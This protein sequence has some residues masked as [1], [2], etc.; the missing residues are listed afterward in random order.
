[1]TQQQL[2]KL[3]KGSYLKYSLDDNCIEETINARKLLCTARFDF[4]GILIYI[5][6]KVQGVKN[7]NWAKNIYR[8]RT[9]AMT[10]HKLC[11][12][13][14]DAKT[15]FDDFV[16][17]LDKLINDFQNDRFNQDQTLIP[18]DK[19]YVPMDG[20][21]RVACAAYFD[22]NVN[23]LRFPDREYKF[24]GYQYLQHELLPAT[25]AD[26]MALESTRWHNDLYV[27]FFW[28]QAHQNTYK[29]KKAQDII[30]TKTDVMYDVKY[31]LSYIAIRNLMIQIYGHMDWLGD[32]DNDFANVTVKVNEVWASNGKV[33]LIITRGRSCEYI[34][35]LKEE[36]REMFGIGLSS[37][38]STDNM[39][40]TK[41]AL[42]ALLNPLSRDFLQ[43]AKPTAFKKSFKLIEKFKETVK[44]NNLSF[45][46]FI[47][48]SSTVLA[49]YGAREAEDLDFYRLP[50]TNISAFSGIEDIEEHDETQKQFYEY[51]ITDYILSPEHFFVF[52]EVKFMSLQNLL[53]FK[54]A[55]YS[56]TKDPKDAGDIGL[57]KNYSQKTNALTQWIVSL[58][59]DYLRRQR[60]CYDY[61]YALIFWRRKEI[62]EKIGLYKPLKALKTEILKH[63]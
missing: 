20:A 61:I 30:Y 10:S 31:K 48:D 4:Y 9:S 29:L 2:N 36:I 47:I 63:I 7:L 37:C 25:I 17:V 62:L 51:P 52:N 35:K 22:K 42:N 60:I 53:K 23:I 12:N 49:I 34:T 56:K 28:P 24:K 41:L 44:S 45:D 6:Q 11:E 57:I 39:R 33:Q 13:G 43:I 21:H 58:K 1:M 18:V 59:Y 14:N 19:D 16:N 38:H 8:E 46:K 32:I 15:S 50:E 54:K 40:E 3:C 55:R 5:D 26:Y 27:I